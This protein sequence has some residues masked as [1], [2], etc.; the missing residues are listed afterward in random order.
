MAP[1]VTKLVLAKINKIKYEL[2]KG[3]LKHSN[4][5]LNPSNTAN[6]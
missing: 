6:F 1:K 4:I 5:Y 2:N 3:Y